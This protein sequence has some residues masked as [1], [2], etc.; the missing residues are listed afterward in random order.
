MRSELMALVHYVRTFTER[1]ILV[2]WACDCLAGVFAV[3]K[4]ACHG[5]EDLDLLTDLFE[6]AAAKGLQ[7]MAL[8]VPRTLNTFC[9]FLSHLTSITGRHEI[10]GSA[11]DF[12]RA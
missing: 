5:R 2:L 12:A 6:A 4:G 7:L 1:N 10:T 9:D 8:W 11:S 3:N